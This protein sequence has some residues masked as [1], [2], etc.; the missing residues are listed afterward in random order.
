MVDAVGPDKVEA[1]LPTYSD[2]LD[3]TRKREPWKT[4]TATPFDWE[5][6]RYHEKLE[7]IKP[8]W[9]HWLS[10]CTERGL[11]TEDGSGSI[12]KAWHM[13]A[14][15]LADEHPEEFTAWRTFWTLTR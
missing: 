7:A 13:V 3:L 12:S 4:G 11:V 5:E 10:V 15:Y 8:A 14:E 9:I 1:K 6:V 2:L